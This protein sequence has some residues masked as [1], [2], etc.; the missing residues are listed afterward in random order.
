MKINAI[1]TGTSGMVGK[2][3]LLECLESPDVD[4]DLIINRS[5]I[6][7]IHPKLKEIILPDFFNLS[8]IKND[9]KGYN[10]CYFCSGVSS[11]GLTEEVY[12][13]L[14]Y[15]LTVNFAQC[16]YELNPEMTFFFFL[17]TA[18]DST[19]KG[20]IM[21]ARVKGK[22][23]NAIAK[24]GFKTAFM[25]RPGVIIPEKGVKSRTPL[26]NSLYVIL[27]PF[28]PLIKKLFPTSVTTSINVGK[29]MI[30]VTLKGFDR[31]F[32]ENKEINRAAGM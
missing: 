22:T 28:M 3:V 18:T 9:L 29:A 12:N 4:S 14:T 27:T 2:G 15:N 17:G 30:N 31:L 10:A 13:N 21:W 1:I 19:E 32:L 5:S 24:M 23:E 7:M 8:T 25:F 11:I 20:K 6:G 16:L 26:Y